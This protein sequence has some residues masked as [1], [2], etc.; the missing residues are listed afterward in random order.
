MPTLAKSFYINIRDSRFYSWLCFI[1][2][3]TYYRDFLH[4]N[5]LKNK[6]SMFMKIYK[7]AGEFFLANAKWPLVPA[8]YRRVRGK[9]FVLSPLVDL[10]ILFPWVTKDSRYSPCSM[11]FTCICRSIVECIP[12][13]STLFGIGRFCAVWCVEGFSG[14]TFDKI[15]HTIVAVLGIL[16][17]GILTFILRII[18]SVL[19]LPVWFLFKCYS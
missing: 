14:S 5:Y 9:D 3:E 7:T 13:V 12:V 1:M 10:V 8:G 18:F 4:E 19:M 6:K 17:L 15:Y 2:K 11:T 16:G